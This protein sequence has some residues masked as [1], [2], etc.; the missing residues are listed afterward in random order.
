[1][2]ILKR[3]IIAILSVCTIAAA[4][5]FTV[6]GCQPEPNPEPPIIESDD[7]AKDG[8]RISLYYPDGNFVKGSDTGNNKT[9]ISVVLVDDNGKQLNTANEG[10]IRENGVATINYKIPGEYKITVINLPIGYVVP[11]VKTSSK[12]SKH[13]I[14]LT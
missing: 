1:M 11:D 5:L 6:T 8:Y 9:R 10:V 7:P 14:D 2:K 3:L 13:R 12:V 4:I